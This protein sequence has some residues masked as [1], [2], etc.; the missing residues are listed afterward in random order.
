MTS[1]GSHDRNRHASS[2]CCGSGVSCSIEFQTNTTL[3]VADRAIC[4]R[5]V[6]RLTQPTEASWHSCAAAFGRERSIPR[7]VTAAPVQ[8]ALHSKPCARAVAKLRSV[9]RTTA[10]SASSA[11]CALT[12][13]TIDDWRGR[14]CEPGLKR[15]SMPKLRRIA[16]VARRRGKRW[17]AECASAAVVTVVQHNRCY[18]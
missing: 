10:E 8:A 16:G 7:V 4:V 17:A 6:E 13:Q 5:V 15:C 12:E 11:P 2:G 3:R 18:V 9:V 1:F 14:T